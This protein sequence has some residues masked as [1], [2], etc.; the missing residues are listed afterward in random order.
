MWDLGPI[1]I[2][3]YAL[4]IIAGIIAAIWITERRWVAR[5]GKRGTV[6][7]I[8]VWAVIFG[9]VGGRLYHV[10]TDNELYFRAGRDPW[11]AFYVWEGGLGIWGAI[12]LGGVGAWIGC[13]RRGIKLPPFADAAAPGIAVAQAIGRW[14]NYFNQ[15]LFG[16]PTTL[17]WGVRIDPD[18]PSTVPGATG[19]QPTFLYESLWDLALAGVLVYVDRRFK[20]GRGRVF[21]LYVMGYTAGRVWIEMLRIDTANHILGLRLNVWTSILVFAGGLAYFLLHPGPR[22]TVVEPD[23]APATEAA[24]GAVAT[25]DDETPA[26]DSTAKADS[27][28]D[29]GTPADEDTPADTT[30]DVGTPADE[31]TGVEDTGVDA[32]EAPAGAAD[33]PADEAADAAPA[34]GAAPADEAA[35]AATGPTDAAAGPTASGPAGA[36][37]PSAATGPDDAATAPAA[38]APADT[39]TRPDGA[40]TAPDSAATSPDGAATGPADGDAGEADAGTS[41]ADAARAGDPAG[42]AERAETA[43]RVDAAADG[44]AEVS[45]DAEAAAKDGVPAGRRKR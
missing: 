18:R 42:P 14:G 9:L 7:D 35:H 40:A 22:E 3:A 17:P 37:G 1:P 4:C 16:R 33:A 41:E 23:A 25:P 29:V 27:A 39:A 28:A 38:A 19:Y 6:S 43:G 44:D 13:R 32:A 34:A 5:G 26:A 8:A 31:D 15:E 36:A 30:A 21:A 12:A 2:R 11:R 20:M 24:A 45:A 10:I